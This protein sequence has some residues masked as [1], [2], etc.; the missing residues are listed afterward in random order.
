LATV[1]KSD[2]VPRGE[3]PAFSRLEAVENGS[4]PGGVGA[5]FELPFD[6]AI[7]DMDGVVTKTAAVNS[8]A[9]KRMFD[10]F[11]QVRAASHNEPFHEFTHARDYLGYVDG[12]PR[13]SGVA[14]FLKSRGIQLTFGTPED[15]P[16]CETVCGLGNRKNAIFN[17][18]IERDGV[19]LYSSTIV[20]IRE[21]LQCGIKVGLATSSKNS[22][23]VLNKTGTAQ[24]FATVIDGIESAKLGL[25]G[26]P[27][28]DIFTTAAATLG[29][30]SARAIVV[31][32]AVSGVQ[33]GA[34]GGFALVVGV[35]RENNAGELR[36][37][38]ADLV[39]PDLGDTSV[40]EICRLVRT[41]RAG[42]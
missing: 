11:L 20:L 36:A 35:A 25:K 26:K 27:D 42:S 39:V 8:V 41:K 13:D 24:F 9:W 29:V 1:D 14:M 33:A 31:E 10:E 37:N 40:A 34:R 6:A 16:D 28:A 21:L 15:L 3:S 7:F 30:P 18:I 4:G 17:E 2:A 22:A 32:D 23:V 38:G 12:R 19:G 5:H